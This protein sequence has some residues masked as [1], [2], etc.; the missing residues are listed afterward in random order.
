MQNVA[1]QVGVQVSKAV[2]SKGASR[3]VPIL[4]AVGVGTYA[5]FDTLQVAK[6]AV[7]LFERDLVVEA[8]VSASD[9]LAKAGFTRVKRETAGASAPP[10]SNT[11][12]A[13][14]PRK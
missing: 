7:E 8:D 14:S 2:L 11:K 1:Q 5:Y 4:G 10:S 6:T 13:S 3:F 12:R 9:D